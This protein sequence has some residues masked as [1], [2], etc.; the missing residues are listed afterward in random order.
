MKLRSKHVPTWVNLIYFI[1]QFIDYK[2]LSKLSMMT[3][4][5]NDL[6]DNHCTCPQCLKRDPR[7]LHKKW[8]RNP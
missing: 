5:R 3:L 4:W 6:Y 2:V 8:K 1:L 7:K